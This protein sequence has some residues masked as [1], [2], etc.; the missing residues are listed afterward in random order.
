ME[1]LIVSRHQAAIEFIARELAGNNSY[2]IFPGYVEIHTQGGV[3]T[4]PVISGDA[5]ADDVRG[6]LVYGNL[7]LGLASEAHAVV[8]IEFSGPPPRGREYSLQDMEAA[9]AHL[10]EYVVL[11]PEKLMALLNGAISLGWCGDPDLV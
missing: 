4:I 9:G 11:R 2:S 3:E 6:K 7:P 5:T 1:K 8:A 10:A